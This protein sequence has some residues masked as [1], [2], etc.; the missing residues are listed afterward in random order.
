[1]TVP[2]RILIII[3]SLN[4]GGTEIH[5]LNI[6]PRLDRTKFQVEVLVFSKI[7]EISLK[8]KK[9]GI[10]VLSPYFFNYLMIFVKNENMK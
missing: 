7:D 3:A 8:I 9:A 5:L 2:A 1:M 10:P 6:L 4:R